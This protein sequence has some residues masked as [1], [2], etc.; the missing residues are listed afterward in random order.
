MTVKYRVTDV[1]KD[2]G[3]TSNEVLSILAKTGDTTKKS[4]T[5]LNEDEL[6]LIFDVITKA[7]AVES[8]D[9]YFAAGEEHRKAAAD[10]KNA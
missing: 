2:L 9:A 5:S 4:Q 10:K 8:F 6:D 3:I 7:H 1:A